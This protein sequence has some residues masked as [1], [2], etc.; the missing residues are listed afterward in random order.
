MAKSVVVA[1]FVTLIV[2]FGVTA[3]V[4]V[5]PFDNPK[6]EAE[7]H[8]INQV[9]RCPQCQNNNIADSNAELAHDLRKKVYQ[10]LREGH[11]RE[12]IIDYMVSRYGDFIVYSPPFGVSTAVLWFGPVIV[13]ISGLVTLYR[14]SRNCGLAEGVE[15]DEGLDSDRDT[16]EKNQ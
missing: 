3:N 8:R 7:F 1:F 5:F 9:L 11:N 13:L 12:Q 2:N 6:Q 14:R 16:Q 15:E 4:D 10:M